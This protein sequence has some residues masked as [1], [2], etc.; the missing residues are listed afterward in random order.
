[1]VSLTAIMSFLLPILHVDANPHVRRHD[2]GIIGPFYLTAYPRGLNNRGNNLTAQD[3][4]ITLSNNGAGQLFLGDTS[5]GSLNVLGM[6]EGYSQL[7]VC[8][9]DGYVYYTDPGQEPPTGSMSTLWSFSTEEADTTRSEVRYG[10]QSFEYCINQATGVVRLRVSSSR[11]IAG[12]S[13]V[14]ILTMKQ[15][16]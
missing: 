13:Y 5:H 10:G 1:M 7:Y 3:N 16:T 2:T 6:G 15:S 9:E 8:T 12:C 14:D 4:S 11:V